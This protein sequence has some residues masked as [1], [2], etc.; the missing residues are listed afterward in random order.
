MY[1]NNNEFYNYNLQLQFTNILLDPSTTKQIAYLINKN[2]LL[3]M[4]LI[5]SGQIPT[6]F[7]SPSKI[8]DTY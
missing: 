6:K 1:W 7:F 8:G 4:G 3:S 5:T 2:N